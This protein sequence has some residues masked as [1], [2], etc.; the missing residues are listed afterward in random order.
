MGSTQ[1]SSIQ[2]YIDGSFGAAQLPSDHTVNKYQ[3]TEYVALVG[4]V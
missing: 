3:R 2:P 1:S 4:E